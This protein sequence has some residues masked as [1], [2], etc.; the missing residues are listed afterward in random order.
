MYREGKLEDYVSEA[1]ARRPAPGGGSVSAC[2]GALGAA[3][4]EMTANFTLGNKKFADVEGEVR[5]VLD[6]LAAR[7]E[8]LLALLDRDVEAYG[9]VDAAYS[10]PRGNDE[11]KAARRE[12]VDHA[13]RGAMEAPLEVM[14]E[15]AAVGRI[16][17]RLAEVGNSNLI[18]D[19][20]VS[21]ILAEAACQGAR[22]N[23]EINLKFLKDEELSARTVAEMDELS[24]AVRE[25]REGAARKVADYLSG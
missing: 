20:G 16:A 5:A 22:L 25:C 14:R 21:A 12:A 7:R 24:G 23:V 9:A 11:E 4:S 2:V 13:L 17:D 18:T 15:C 8:T 19:A 1:A 10:M 6:E 3:M